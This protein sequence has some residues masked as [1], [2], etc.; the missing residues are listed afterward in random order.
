MQQISLITSQ[1]MLSG[2]I[3]RTIHEA[4]DDAIETLERECGPYAPSASKR[5]RAAVAR[6][7]AELA[8]HGVCDFERLRVG[9]LK[10]VYFF[11]A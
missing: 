3:L 1:N 4:F 10:A 8:K 6:R 9:A 11:D 2:A 7:M 5:I